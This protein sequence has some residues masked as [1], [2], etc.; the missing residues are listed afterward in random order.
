M[1]DKN[2]FNATKTDY[3]I[4]SLFLGEQMGFVDS[5][6][7]HYPKLFSLYKKLKSQDWDEIEIPFTSCNSEFKTCP[8]NVY[9]MMKIT[10]AWQ[11]EADSI[12]ARSLYSIGAP[13]ISS[14]E[15]NL[16]WQRISDNENLHALTYSEIVRNSFDNLNEIITE[17]QAM[18]KAV[19][20]SVIVSKI[21]N[22]TYILSHKLALGE[23]DRNSQ[24]TY[25]TIFMFIVAMYCLERIQFMDS[26]AVT[27]AIADSGLFV[28]IGKAVQK[29]CADEFDIHV[30]AHKVTLD[31][32]LQTERGLM[33]F[34]NLK[35]KIQELI[36][37]VVEQ[38]MEWNRYLFSEG[39][40]LIGMDLDLLNTY[41]MF[42]A[43]DVYQFF[44]MQGKYPFPDKN[45]LSWIEEW[46]NIDMIQ[47]SPQ[48]EKT[49]AYLMG[50]IKRDDDNRQF[51]LEGI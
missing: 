10:L 30:K 26:F 50:G 51:D 18:E 4:S 38:E 34:N 15:L 5:I 46:I 7:K 19:E 8:K 23:V 48:E 12:A 37:S 20:R 3:H 24:E 25:E 28:P 21:L 43:K 14:T 49:T 9:D 40:E 31:Y 11:W 32:E 29:I 36:D 27:F 39:R 17:M 35:P 16:L 45:P 2:I 22:D 6:N 13:F 44:G 42:N 33:A 47:G 1:I 41:L